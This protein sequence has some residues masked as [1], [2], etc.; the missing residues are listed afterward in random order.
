MGLSKEDIGGKVV[1]VTGASSGN[2][3]A[4]ALLLADRGARLVLAA[5][6]AELLEATALEAESLGGEALAV[7]CDVTVREQVEA[8]AGAALERF[9]RIDA[10]I[11]NAGVIAWS[12]FEDTTEEEFRRTLEVNPMGAVYGSWVVLPAMRS[13]NSGGTEP[14]SASALSANSGAAF[15]L[16]R[17]L[18]VRRWTQKYASEP[19]SDLVLPHQEP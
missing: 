16:V 5:R 14:P 8:V 1:V 15:S 7:S 12:L 10:W 3:K 19:S 18:R 4:M 2:G 17:R 11:N 13:Q 9:G 6:R